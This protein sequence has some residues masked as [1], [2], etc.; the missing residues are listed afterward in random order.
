LPIR[1]ALLLQSL[2]DFDEQAPA[3]SFATTSSLVRSH[4]VLKACNRRRDDCFE[5]LS[6]EPVIEATVCCVG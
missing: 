5:H 1:Q 3:I 2:T 6:N 4:A